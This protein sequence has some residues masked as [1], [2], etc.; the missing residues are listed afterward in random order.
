MSNNQTTLYTIRKTINESHHAQKIID[1]FVKKLAA[2]GILDF[3]FNPEALDALI[4]TF[5]Y[6]GILKNSFELS[7]YSSKRLTRNI[8]DEL[9]QRFSEKLFARN[10]FTLEDIESNLGKIIA[11]FENAE[12][13]LELYFWFL[14]YAFRVTQKFSQ[15]LD[16]YC[17]A[18]PD[19]FFD[20][21]SYITEAIPATV[22]A[23]DDGYYWVTDHPRAFS[24][25][26]WDESFNAM[27]FETCYNFLL[28][29]ASKTPGGKFKWE[30]QDW[31]SHVFKKFIINESFKTI[32][33]ASERTV[34][35]ITAYVNSYYSAHKLFVHMLY[36]RAFVWVYIKDLN[37]FK[38]LNADNRILTNYYSIWG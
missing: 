7:N 23:T 30:F 15:A 26:S 5:R 17:Q 27:P 28:K 24:K 11:D 19:E 34:K 22:V 10:V 8:S 33:K 38:I 29:Y 3:F 25:I 37:S 18:N 21:S 13:A 31:V 35:N 9:T 36:I 14:D 32:T 2:E 12:N 16:S 4:A 6:K 1:S 20:Y